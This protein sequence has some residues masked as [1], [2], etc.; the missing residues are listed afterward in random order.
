ME[1]KPKRKIFKR[2]LEFIP[3][4]LKGAFESI[5]VVGPIINAAENIS[6]EFKGKEKKH[7]YVRVIVGAVCMIGVVYAFLTKMITV[8]DL[9]DLLNKVAENF[10]A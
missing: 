1:Q 2:I 4:I 9:I 10:N 8:E 5:P 3:R 6:A 7:D